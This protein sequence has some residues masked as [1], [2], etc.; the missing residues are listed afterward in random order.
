MLLNIDSAGQDHQQ[1]IY[2][3]YVYDIV[4]RASEPEGTELTKGRRV[5]EIDSHGG[6]THQQPASGGSV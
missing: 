6:E 5:S 1:S 4:V 2:N 3:I